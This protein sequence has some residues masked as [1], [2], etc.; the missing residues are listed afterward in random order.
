[1]RVVADDMPPYMIPNSIQ[2]PKR[3]YAIAFDLDTD[4]LKAT[5]HNPS[6]QNA[7]EDIRRV[8]SR[9]DF[10]RQQGS[11]YFGD[12]EKVD[13]VRC[14][15]AVQDL[16]QT[17]AWFAGAVSDIRMLRIEENNDLMPA[18]ENMRQAIQTQAT[19]QTQA[20]QLQAPAPLPSGRADD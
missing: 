15:L 14:V 10:S 17:Y 5:Y 6:W 20:L 4:V 16:T 12:A 1:M 8:L 19:A 9:Y 11:V 2:W 7:Y 13:P 18:I 3:M